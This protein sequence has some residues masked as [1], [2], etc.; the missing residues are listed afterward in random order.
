MC[1]FV[2]MCVCVWK[3]PQETAQEQ[4]P[5]Q[6]MGGKRIE[7]EGREN[8]RCGCLW[9]FYLFYFIFDCGSAHVGSLS[10][11]PPAKHCDST[12]HTHE[13]AV[14]STSRW[15]IVLLDDKRECARMNDFHMGVCLQSGSEADYF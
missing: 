14:S 3:H 7:C 8:R 2:C 1:S 5:W 12:A 4:L 9:F 10:T 6:H 13:H 15:P 11:F